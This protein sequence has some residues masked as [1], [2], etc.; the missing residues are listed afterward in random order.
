[1]FIVLGLGSVETCIALGPRE[2]ESALRGSVRLRTLLARMTASAGCAGAGGS[3]GAEG[4]CLVVASCV[5]ICED[6]AAAAGS[7]GG[8]GG[9]IS[10]AEVEVEV[11]L[12][13]GLSCGTTG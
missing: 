8:G 5:W 12:L 11:G 4:A 13:V 7:R 10:E 9:G 2:T 3:V 6:G 1:M